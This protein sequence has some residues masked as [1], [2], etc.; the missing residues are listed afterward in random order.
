[1]AVSGFDPV[2]ELRKVIK[3]DL[4]PAYK[5]FFAAWKDILLSLR[6]QKADPAYGFDPPLPAT[7]GKT[8]GMMCKLACMAWSAEMQRLPINRLSHP[9]G[10]RH[11]K[12]TS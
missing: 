10:T 7:A 6:R 8:T 12:G 2:A 11:P 3:P 4:P 9:C 5:G 1:M